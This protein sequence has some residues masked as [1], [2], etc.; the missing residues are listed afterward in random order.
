MT[1][2]PARMDVVAGTQ[3]DTRGQTE[4]FLLVHFHGQTRTW[5]RSPSHYIALEPLHERTVS[6]I[7]LFSSPCNS[8]RTKQVNFTKY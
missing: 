1:P 5:Q 3:W 8:F 2:P 7:P 6:P 4:R